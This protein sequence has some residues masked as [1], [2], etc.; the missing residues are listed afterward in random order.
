M[1]SRRKVQARLARIIRVM[2]RFSQNWREYARAEAARISSMRW[3]TM[4]LKP[5]SSIRR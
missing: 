1:R 3:L 2:L 4:M 5:R